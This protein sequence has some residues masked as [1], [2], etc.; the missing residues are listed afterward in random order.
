MNEESP[1]PPPLTI[2]QKR[3][4]AAID[5]TRSDDEEDTAARVPNLVLA[6][7]PN[8]VSAIQRYSEK[9]RL[10]TD[11]SAEVT[12]LLNEPP[13]FR[14]AKLMVNLLHLSNQIQ[15]I[16]TAQP[17]YEVSA[18]LEKNLINYG[19]AVLLSSKISAYKGAIPTNILLDI[20]KK[21]RFDLPPGIESIPADFAKVVAAV[22]E[23]LTQLRAKFKKALAASMKTS[24]T[25]KT[26]APG[27]DH[28]NIFKLTQVFVDGTQCKVTVEL[29]ARVALMRSVFLQDSGPKFWDK[30]DSSLAAIRAQA[31]GNSKKITKA[32][33]H[34]LTTDQSEHGVKDYEIT[35]AGV[36]E[37]QQ[38]VDNLIDAGTA[39]LA[40]SVTDSA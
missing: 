25:D 29:C 31:Q 22:Q 10:R 8:M 36:D 7:N 15:G 14:H 2:A 26:I 30:L 3:S 5:E 38:Q 20:V 19:V 23:I 4:H 21:N 37:V 33:R 35:D 1:V 34:V 32:F 28:Q 39:D 16:V 40:S 6:A 12:A 18:N 24:K 17:A 9:K 27:P 13:A 11:Q